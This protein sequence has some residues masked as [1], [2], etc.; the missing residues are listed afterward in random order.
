MGLKV[1]TNSTLL[2]LSAHEIG[3]PFQS[4]SSSCGSLSPTHFRRDCVGTAVELRQ[5]FHGEINQITGHLLNDQGW[6]F[7]FVSVFPCRHNNMNRKLQ[8]SYSKDFSEEPELQEFF[9]WLA[10]H[11][12]S[13]FLQTW[14]EIF[15]LE[16]LTMRRNFHQQNNRLLG[17]LK[18]VAARPYKKINMCLCHLFVRCTVL[19]QR[20]AKAMIWKHSNANAM[21]W[22]HSNAKNLWNDLL[23]SIILWPLLVAWI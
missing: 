20:W 14:P 15:P 1:S 10:S 6:F 18:F 9:L 2:V 17:C 22:K 4:S 12:I 3:I 5:S 13:V 23:T 8:R 19:R 21:I 11:G 7:C 16:N